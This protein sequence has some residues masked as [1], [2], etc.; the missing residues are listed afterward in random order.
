VQK[1]VSL[2]AEP[3]IVFEDNPILQQLSEPE[4]PDET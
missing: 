2:E 1:S 4:L 3:E